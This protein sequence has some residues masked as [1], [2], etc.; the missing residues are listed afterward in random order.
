M[1][2][3]NTKG[4]SSSID[5]GTDDDDDDDI[6]DDDDDVVSGLSL[7]LPWCVHTTAIARGQATRKHMASAQGSGRHRPTDRPTECDLSV[8]STPH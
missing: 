6:D 1:L 4:G 7:S 5:Y 8:G 2:R 3:R